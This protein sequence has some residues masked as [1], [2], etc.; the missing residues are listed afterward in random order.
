MALKL[1]EV[2][3]PLKDISDAC[4]AEKKVRTGLIANLHTWWARRPVAAARAVLFAQLV[5]DPSSKPEMFSS[6]EE[7][8]DERERL[9]DILRGLLNP[10]GPT[11]E[12]LIAAQKEIHKSVGEDVFVIDPF[13]GGGAIPVEA[14]RLGLNVIASDLNPVAVLLN[15]LTL[16]ELSNADGHVAV[17]PDETRFKGTAQTRGLAGLAEDVE[18]YAEWMRKEVEKKF[19]WL[20][21]TIKTDDGTERA[22]ISWIWAR[23]V[24]C[25]NPAC[26]IQA[27]LVR[28]FM[29]SNKKGRETWVDPVTTGPGEKVTFKL[30]TGT[31]PRVDRTVTRQGAACL[32]CG[33]A[34]PFQY[35]REQGRDGKISHELMAIA[36]LG[37]RRRIYI[38]PSQEQSDLA[39]S[40][41][42]MD[43]FGTELVGKARVNVGNYGLNTH[44]SL[45][46]NRQM[47]V[48]N[49]FASLVSKAKA[50]V[51]IDSENDESYASTVAT[52]LGT[53]V[54]KLANRVNSL[55]RWSSSVECSLDLFSQQSIAM[56]WDF[57]E[58]NPVGFSSGSFHSTVESSARSLRGPLVDYRR[59]T[60]CSVSQENAATRE[61]PK[62]VVVCT[63]PPYFDN[64][65]YADLADFFYVW[66]R[67]SLVD[68]H[69]DIFSTLLTPKME[70]LV[71]SP[72]RFGGSKEEATRHFEDGFRSVFE[73]I[74]K[75][76]N[77]DIPMTIFYAYK[78][79]DNEVD[80]ADSGESG[81]SATGWEKFLQGI[82]DAGFQVTSTWPMRTERPGRMIGQGANALASSVVLSCRHRSDTAGIT[83]RQGFIRKLR[84]EMAA[85]LLDLHSGG[86]QPVDMAQSSIGPGMAVFTSFSKVLD[87]ADNVMTVGTALQLINQVLDELQ[88]EQEAEFDTDTRWAVSWFEQNGMSG[89]DFGEALN[90]ATA[91]GTAMNALER[92]GLVEARSGRVRL[93]DRSEYS[94]DWD[95]STDRR[96][97]VWEICQHL[98]RRLDGDGG[99]IAAASLLRQVGGLGDAARDLSYRLYEIANRNGWADEARAYNNLAAEWPD[100]VALAAQAPQDPTTLF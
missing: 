99:A 43:P 34:M 28:S 5:D 88:T 66:L 16:Q 6:P 96:L 74:S 80:E 31:K 17:H 57:A 79:E 42:A 93:L 56:M 83:D 7:V 3:L 38:E 53:C 86:V 62:N 60:K 45:F 46:T 69:P 54:S 8:A 67:L 76:H 87:E 35:I 82:V 13:A 10:S 78:Q 65:S 30:K 70:E 94:D 21:P 95:P 36:A 33:T 49:E 63:D 25:P 48:L 11:P 2:A 22:V 100:L 15:T 52:L 27:P 68:V 64:I 85:K 61:Y 4:V 73:K 23:A 44:A 40:V 81:A 91:R 58:A 51:L 14:Q 75:Q 47:I 39:K 59:T 37:D 19:G 9:F 26:R 12:V 90:L 20:Y 89:G 77:P 1:I 32:A 71:A 72:H 55:V 41:S 98:I 29:L 92:S 50:Q 24:P 84:L 97:T 18:W